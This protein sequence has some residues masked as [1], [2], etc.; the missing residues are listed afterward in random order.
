M[1]SL[2]A[3]VNKP[4]LGGR[5]ANPLCAAGFSLAIATLSIQTQ[6]ACHY[7]VNDQWNGGFTATVK[8]TNSGTSA[9][10]GWNIN[11][12]YSGSDKVTSSWNVN[13]TGTNPYT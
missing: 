13:L 12:R 5:L 2:Q 6:A 3:S 10:N 4:R 8:I 1:S 11:W 7:V 9:I